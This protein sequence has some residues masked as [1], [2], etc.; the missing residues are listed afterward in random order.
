SASATA[1]WNAVTSFCLVRTAR[2]SLLPNLAR[3]R[4]AS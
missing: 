2:G 4:P 3:P 1:A